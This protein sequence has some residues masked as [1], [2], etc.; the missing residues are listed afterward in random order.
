MK[1]LNLAT[2]S[3]LLI[4]TASYSTDKKHTVG[5]NVG[6][7]NGEFKGSTND[8]D[9]FA[10]AYF[11]YNYQAFNDISFEVAYTSAKAIDDWDWDCKEPT[12]ALVNCNYDGGKA[13]LF[14]TA[15]EDFDLDGLVIAIKAALPLSQR[16]DLYG[17][18]GIQY[19][20]YD[21]HNSR[22][23]SQGDSGTGSFI[24]AGWQYRWDLGIGMDAGIRYQDMG[25]LTFTSYNAGISYTF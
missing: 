5:L 4:S 20:D 3:L 12:N 2:L 8:G 13:P 10:Q 15:A 18:A 9:G 14:N 6:M 24:E 19:Y 25:D 17:K 16:N 11:F 7:A 1:L 21:L 22:F 23:Y